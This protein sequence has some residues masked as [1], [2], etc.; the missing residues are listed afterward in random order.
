MGT[1]LPRDAVAALVR[2]TEGWPAGVYL[3][4]LS[5]RGTVDEVTAAAAIAGTD[6]FIVD[7]FREEVLTRESA[8]TVRFLLRTAV[9][10]EMSGPLCDAV[11]GHSGSATWL[12]EIERRNLF[13]VPQDHDGRWYRYHRL[14][15]EMLLSELRQ[16]E[17]GEEQRIHRRAAAWHEEHGP[18]D[19]AIAHALAGR[20]TPMAARLVAAYGQR[21][22]NAGRIYMVRGWLEDLDGGALETI[23]RSPSLPDGSGPSPAIPRAPSGA[24]APRNR[25]AGRR[26]ADRQRLAG[27]QDRDAP[28]RPSAAWRRT[29]ARRRPAGIRARTSRGAVVP[30]GGHAPRCRP[31]AQRGAGRRG[32]GMGAG[33]LLR[34]RRTSRR[35]GE[36]G[37]RATVFACRRARRL[38]GRAGLCHR[39]L[40]TDRNGTACSNTSSS[41]TS[42]VARARLAVHTR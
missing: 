18:P 9:L 40:D 30:A 12:A 7:Y 41:I 26:A 42:Y 11:L 35:C 17:P 23:R 2:R 38:G 6:K 31:A 20:D 10:E 37:P 3:A 13:L 29:D 34:P 5:V 8:E 28:R 25:H 22:V 14:F 24:C 15:G 4:G 1:R 16:R 19:R 27:L 36:H 33:R 39:V 21:F 32:E